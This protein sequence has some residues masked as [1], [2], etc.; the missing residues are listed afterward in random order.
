MLSPVINHL[1]I[2]QA[3]LRI[4]NIAQQSSTRAN[5]GLKWDLT[6]VG[7]IG[8]KTAGDMTLLNNNQSISGGMRFKVS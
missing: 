3:T 6:R 5:K 1:N 7:T 4:Q 8:T 2:Q